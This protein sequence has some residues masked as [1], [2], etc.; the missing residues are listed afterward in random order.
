MF[1]SVHIFLKK[2]IKTQMLV[3]LLL[4]AFGIGACDNLKFDEA[5]QTPVENP[6]NVFYTTTEAITINPTSLQGLENASQVSILKEPQY[7]EARFT[8]NGLVYYKLTSTS[9][10]NRDNLVLRGKTSAGATIDKQVEILILPSVQDLPCYAGA[11]G[12][13]AELEASLPITLNVTANDK[14]CTTIG[15]VQIE[16]PPKHGIVSVQ[17]QAIIYI[18]E[19]DYIGSDSFLYRINISNNK[20]PVAPVELTIVEPAACATGLK[21]DDLSITNYIE[22]SKIAIDILQNDVICSL[23]NKA[24]LKI[25]SAPQHGKVSIDSTNFDTPI[26][27]YQADKGF[28]GDDTFSYGLYRDQTNFIQAKVSVS[29]K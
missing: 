18:P 22:E 27:L 29:I 12:D 13:R 17:G 28:K 15:G 6:N 7:G 24:R 26:I 23:Y 14:T 2:T 8:D 1:Q 25:V 10:I 3:G 4:L 21:D 19:K 5:S 20:N 16:L 11:I 9:S